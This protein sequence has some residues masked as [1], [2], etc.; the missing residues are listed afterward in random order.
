MRG[1]RVTTYPLNV[2]RRYLDDMD[3]DLSL[4]PQQH[5]YQSDSEDTATGSVRRFACVL[6]HQGH[7]LCCRPCSNAVGEAEEALTIE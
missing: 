2:F 6:C 5:D 7:R 3:K 4:L 1:Q